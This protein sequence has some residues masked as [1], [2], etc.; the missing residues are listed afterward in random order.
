M[1]T[2]KF[3]KIIVIASSF[4]FIQACTTISDRAAKVQV[5]R[6]MSTLLDKCKNL[7]PIT[8][9]AIANEKAWSIDRGVQQAEANGRDKVA[10]IGGDTFVV[11]NTDDFNGFGLSSNNK[12]VVQGVAMKCY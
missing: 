1:R 2:C 10:E 9:E 11:L 3:H 6:Q 8:G 7:G 4:L 12:T 5:Q